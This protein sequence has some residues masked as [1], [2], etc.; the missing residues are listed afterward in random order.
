ML[1]VQ[2]LAIGKNVDL[3]ALVDALEVIP[4][5]QG[6]LIMCDTFHALNG[7]YASGGYGSNTS[8]CKAEFKESAATCIQFFTA[9]FFFWLIH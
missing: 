2:H 1:F 6:K 5:G 3:I 4:N 7:G 9:L 8:S